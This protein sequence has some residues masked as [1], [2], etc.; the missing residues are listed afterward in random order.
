MNQKYAIHNFESY[1]KVQYQ[2][3]DNT[4]RKKERI[5]CHFCDKLSC[6]REIQQLNIVT[7]FKYMKKQKSPND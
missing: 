5:T 1:N 4:S 2:P 3:F 7:L 6:S